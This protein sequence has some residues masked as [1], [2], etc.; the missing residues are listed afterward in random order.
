MTSLPDIAIGLVTFKRTEMALRTVAST[1][2]NLKYPREKIG[3]YIADDGSPVEHFN[4]VMNE[5]QKNDMRVIGSH[6]Q[7]MRK[8]GDE[9]THFAGVGWNKCLGICHQSSDFVL[10]LEDDWVL[11]EE[12]DLE[13]YVRLLQER[14]DVGLCSFRILTVGADIHTVGYD[15]RM[16]FQYERGTQYAYS[17]NPYLR[18]A[19]Y[20]RTYGIFAE[21]RNPG[22]IELDQDD[23]YRLGTG[24][25]IW[26][27]VGISQWGSWKHIGS[28]KTW[29]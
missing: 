17:G 18:H 11:D 23:K 24:P 1:I 15:G 3:W 21:N 12:L 14:E 19:R 26:R 6:N 8:E 29:S 4:A 5:V 13:P 20:T 27:P 9:N 2:E 7:R 10:W 16:Y 28:E 22:L 25:R